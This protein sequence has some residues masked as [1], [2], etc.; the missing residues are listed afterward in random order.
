MHVCKLIYCDNK[1][2]KLF[3]T[4]EYGKIHY[5][6]SD[7]NDKF[8]IIITKKPQVFYDKDYNHFF[9]RFFL[10]F[11]CFKNKTHEPD[12]NRVKRDNIISIYISTWPRNILNKKKIWE[13]NL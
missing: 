9:Y 10:L 12:K 5:Q 1:M 6:L 11:F 3:K 13:K 7:K 8:I 4:L 2:N